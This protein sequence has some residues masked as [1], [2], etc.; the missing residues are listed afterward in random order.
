MNNKDEESISKS[1]N[2]YEN[3]IEN[4]KN[5]YK[6]QTKKKNQELEELFEQ[7]E[8]ENKELKKEIIQT[9]FELQEEKDKSKNM[10]ISFYNINR[11]LYNN[12]SSKEIKNLETNGA[13][14]YYIFLNNNIKIIKENSEKK[15]IELTK[16]YNKELKYFEETQ[17]N[18]DLNI[19]GFLNKKDNIEIV[20]NKIIE[21]NKKYY[22]KID[23]LLKENYNK[24]KFS[25]TLN[26]KYE[27][28]KEEIYFL[29]SRIFQEK[30]NILNKIN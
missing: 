23:I 22:N 21:E 30:S 17:K 5:E 14:Y 3:K 18:T 1:S 28:S 4:L 11:N 15:I 19:K 26:Q 25:I 13:E 6:F 8:D 10:K 2:M 12:Q 16:N 29:K 7:M 24:E 9:K 20:Y 27:I